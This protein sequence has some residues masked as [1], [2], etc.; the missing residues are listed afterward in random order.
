MVL[1]Q[2][3]NHSADNESCGYERLGTRLLN[4][5]ILDVKSGGVAASVKI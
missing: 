5:L 2:P 4:K 1:F 3:Q